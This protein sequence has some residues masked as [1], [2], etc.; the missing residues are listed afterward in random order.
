MINRNNSFRDFCSGIRDAS[1]K[2]RAPFYIKIMYSVFFLY[3][4]LYSTFL[5][6]SL[7]RIDYSL[8]PCR[9]FYRLCAFVI[10]IILW[11]FST[12]FDFFNYHYIKTL[13]YAAT[14]Y[15]EA[16]ILITIVF[17]L[18]SRLLL[19]GIMSIKTDAIFT[20]QM[21]LFLARITTELPLLP[22]MLLLVKG[23]TKPILS[24]QSRKAL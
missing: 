4:I 2:F 5:L 19:P 22:L 3:L 21:V 9:A 12:A 6:Y 10:P 16:L 14:A 1:H 17:E 24:P 18:L 15:S 11:L 20:K 7:Y 13:T 23:F 8:L